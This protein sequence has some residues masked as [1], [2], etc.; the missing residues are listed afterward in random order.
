MSCSIDLLHI[1]IWTFYSGA[2]LLLASVIAYNELNPLDKEYRLKEK[3]KI[4][5][6]NQLKQFSTAQKK[7]DAKRNI[8]QISTAEMKI[9]R[10]RKMNFLV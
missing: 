9:A 8:K 3:N 4:R 5:E 7:I 2:T 1:G 6:L 10:K